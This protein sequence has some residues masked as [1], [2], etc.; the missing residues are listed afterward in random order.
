MQPLYPL[1]FKEILRDYSF[2]DRWIATEFTKPGLPR[3]HP[4]SETWEVCDRPG[5]SSVVTNGAFAGSSLHDLI[6]SFGDEL[7]GRAV[8]AVTGSRFPLLVK[9]LDASNPLGEQV[10]QDDAVAAEQGLKDPGKTEAWY[11]LRTRPGATIHCGTRN[12]TSREDVM[13]ALIAGTIRDVMEM[14]TVSPGDAFLLHAGTM[15]YSRG[16]VLF[17]EIMQ[18]STVGVS[19]NRSDPRPGSQS[20]ERWAAEAI[21]SIRLVP[22][23]DCRIPPVSIASG[24][25]RVSFIFACGYFALERLDLASPHALACTGER[26]R[27]LT[28]IE[29]DSTVSCRGGLERLEPGQTCL[30]PASLG[31]VHVSPQGRCSVLHAYVP[32]LVHDIIEPLRGAGVGDADI[33]ALGGEASRNP[34]PDLIMRRPARRFGGP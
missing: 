34:F 23:S 7:L 24:A 21:R 30:L 26:F 13:K 27:V 8:T 4:L 32:D 3:E 20:P 28:Q 9:L 11:M 19:L 22:G 14:R 1:R 17:Y 2:G 10:H 25:N 29:G 15:H 12:G 16:G 18:N 5:E 33:M 6:G 31:D